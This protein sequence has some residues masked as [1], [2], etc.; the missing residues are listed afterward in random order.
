MDISAV[1]LQG[2][3]QALSQVAQA[4]SKLASIGINAGDGAPLDT[5][6]LSDAAVSLLSGKD[7]FAAN[8]QLLKVADEMKGTT[9]NLLA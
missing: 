5:A 1:A 7:A 9:L 8:I 6:D 3:C 4:G 2:V